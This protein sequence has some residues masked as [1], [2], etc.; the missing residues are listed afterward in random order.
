MPLILGA[1]IRCF[2]LPITRLFL[3]WPCK[4]LLT[5]PWLVAQHEALA[6]SSNVPRMWQ[7]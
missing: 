6:E 5:S 3:T 1:Q 4:L 2:L 7:F